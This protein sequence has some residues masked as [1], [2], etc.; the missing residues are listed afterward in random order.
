[1]SSSSMGNAADQH[2][3]QSR[4]EIAARDKISELNAANS[5]LLRLPAEIRNMIYDNVFR[6]QVLVLVPREPGSTDLFEHYYDL[7]QYDPRVRAHDKQ[8][9]SLLRVPRQLYREGALMPYQLVTFDF[10][11]NTSFYPSPLDVLGKF[12][13]IRS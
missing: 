2:L 9:L 12:L 10:Y 7:K 11:C 3:E 4:S 5:P 6:D 1:M 13:V 8:C